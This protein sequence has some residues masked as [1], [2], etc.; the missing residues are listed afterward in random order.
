[1][2]TQEF[3]EFGLVEGTCVRIDYSNMEVYGIYHHL[4]NGKLQLM[5]QEKINFK[6]NWCEYFT[7]CPIYNK[8]GKAEGIM[9]G[10]YDCSICICNK[11]LKDTKEE[12]YVICDK[13]LLP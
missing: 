10:D 12:H 5:S 13:S 4:E 11:E 3:A 2:K 8:K 6:R 9:V 7:P 1:M